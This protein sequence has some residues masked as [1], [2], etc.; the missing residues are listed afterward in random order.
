MEAEE[1]S[2][3]GRGGV[4]EGPVVLSEFSFGKGSCVTAYLC[5][6]CG[7]VMIDTNPAGERGEA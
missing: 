3:A 6:A 4:P 1:G 2:P 5:R 7:K